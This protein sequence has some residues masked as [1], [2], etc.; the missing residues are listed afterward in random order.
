M[1]RWGNS[2]GLPVATMAWR[3]DPVIVVLACLRTQARAEAVRGWAPRQLFNDPME[4]AVETRSLPNVMGRSRAVAELFLED[5]VV[6]AKGGQLGSLVA[7][8]LAGH[9]DAEEVKELVAHGPAVYRRRWAPERS[10]K[11]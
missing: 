6:L 1:R 3:A 7:A 8:E 2:L 5:A 10:R 11:H 4:R 9:G